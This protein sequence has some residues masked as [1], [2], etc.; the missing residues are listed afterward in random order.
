MRWLALALLLSGCVTE[1][2]TWET[3]DAGTLP[4]AGL[5]CMPRYHATFWC[6]EELDRPDGSPP[7]SPWTYGE[8]SLGGDQ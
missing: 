2:V 3:Y 6:N 8:C 4:D 7:Q 5:C 1:N